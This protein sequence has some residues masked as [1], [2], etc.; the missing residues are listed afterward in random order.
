MPT[1]DPSPAPGNRF[2]AQVGLGHLGDVADQV[3][4]R[5]A[6]GI[7]AL[8]LRL[9]DESRQHRA[10]LLQ[11]RDGLEGGV[12]EDHDRLVAGRGEAAEDFGRLGRVE[13]D[14]A[15]HAGQHRLERVP[16][17]REQLDRIAGDVLGDDAAA[18]VEN[19]AP[20]R[21]QRDR[22]EAI[23]LG[24][25]LELVVL[26]DLGPEERAREDQEGGHE[27]PARDVGALPHPV[28]IEA[29]HLTRPDGS[30]TTRGTPPGPPARRAPTSA[31]G[32]GCTRQARSGGTGRR[33]RSPRAP[34]GRASR[35]LPR[36]RR[37]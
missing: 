34:G 1:I 9:D 15:A 2:A 31:P 29:V 23:G 5:L 30:R 11:P 27:H 21:R 20:G 19:G 25:E 32:A 22:P 4:D 36:R 28:G 6:G 17:R 12:A 8:G 24:L 35:G 18:P 3:R 7:E 13:R 16:A 14:V 10:M 26:D 33:S 37:R